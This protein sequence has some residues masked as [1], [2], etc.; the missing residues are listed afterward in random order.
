[1]QNFLYVIGAH[2]SGPVKLGISAVP[3]RRVKQLQTGHSARL[4]LFHEEPVSNTIARVMER[5]LHRDVGYLRLRGEWFQLTVEQAVA[6]VKFTIIQYEGVD[7]LVEKMR[8][9]RI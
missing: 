3:A 2:T 9:R 1:V 8:T 7:S 5:L 4:H 6:Q